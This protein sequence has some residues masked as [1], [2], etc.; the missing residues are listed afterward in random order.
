[1]KGRILLPLL[2]VLLT[3]VS[4]LG[5]TEKVTSPQAA[6][7]SF[8][9]GYYPVRVHDINWHGRDTIIYE[10][11]GGV[12]YPMTIDQLNNEIYNIDSLAY[13]S[14]ISAVTSTVVSTGTLFYCYADNTDESY[15]WS[16]Y[17]SI[18]FT[19]RLLFTVVSTDGT[20][21]R[22]YNVKVNVRTVFPDSLIWSD[23]DDTGF[24]V[25]TDMSVLERSDT[26]FCFG[27][28]ASGAASVTYRKDVN[29]NWNGAN[30]INGFSAADW[31][32]GV[33]LCAGR[34]YTVSDGSLYGSTDGV[35]WSSVKTGVKNLFVSLN[36]DG[37]LWAVSGD[38]EIIRTSDMAEWVTV[39]SVPEG[40][41]GSSTIITSYPLA[42]NA[43]ITRWVL[44]GV[45]D[46]NPYASVW[47]MLTGDTVWTQVDAPD[48]TELRLPAVQNLSMIRYDGDLFCFGRGSE[49]FRQ[50]CDNGIT[51]YECN[52]YTE[53]FSSW[54][55]YMQLPDAIKGSDIGLA[56]T[57]DSKGSIWIMTEDGQVWRGAINRLNRR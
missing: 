41:P 45:S 22:K 16:S 18:D 2:A 49:W 57:V 21:T 26:I 27:K 24:P 56:C 42:T 6:I 20:Y 50:S 19:R 36:D 33:T 46:D 10:T 25:L 7:T 30:Q 35:N 8:T 29:E 38:N 39:Q 15:L 48:R 14:D 44:V 43:N 37:L 12:M 47:T 5:E 4:C 51:W 28:D 1:M 17:D 40:F 53:E 23:S 52:S 11:Q 3:G 32:Q 34:F 55:R 13:G 54:N 31:K 9:I